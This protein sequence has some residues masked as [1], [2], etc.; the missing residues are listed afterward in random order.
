MV[1]C[2]NGPHTHSVEDVCT[3][4]G[5]ESADWLIDRVRNGS[6]PG[7]KVVRQLRFSDADIQRIIDM[8]AV[9]TKVVAGIRIPTPT[10]R[11]SRRLKE[12]A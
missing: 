5:C 6:F 9:E 8:C 11:S 4:I 2:P 3:L 7:R 12:P 1:D 10:A